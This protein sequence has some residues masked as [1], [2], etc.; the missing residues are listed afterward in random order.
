MW[1]GA[2]A[3]LAYLWIN[4]Y[5]A[6]CC[7]SRKINVVLGMGCLSQ[8]EIQLFRPVWL[9]VLLFLTIIYVWCLVVQL[10]WVQDVWMGFAINGLLVVLWIVEFILRFCYLKNVPAF[11]SKFSF[12]H[13][14]VLIIPINDIIGSFLVKTNFRND[15]RINCGIYVLAT[16]AAVML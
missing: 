3:Y 12:L 8:E 9:I 13:F 4:L 7:F 6:N 15:V 16:I 14:L 2:G 11:S 10:Q 1:T 5:V